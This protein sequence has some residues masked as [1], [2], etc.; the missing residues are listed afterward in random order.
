MVP[1]VGPEDSVRLPG[2]TEVLGTQMQPGSSLVPAVSDSHVN[3]RGLFKDG[4]LAEQDWVRKAREKRTVGL[5]PE[6]CGRWRG[7][8]N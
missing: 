3:P 2:G 8:L 5:E 1:A 6:L 4:S 7:M